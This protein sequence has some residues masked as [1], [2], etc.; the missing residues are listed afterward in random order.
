MVKRK[1]YTTSKASAEELDAFWRGDKDTYLRLYNQR[2]KA[3]SDALNNTVS[4]L[5]SKG[6]TITYNPR[7]NE[8]KEVVITAKGPSI[9]EKAWDNTSTD[10]KIDA[11]VTTASFIPGLDTAADIA[12]SANQFRQ[13]NWGWGLLGLGATFVPGLSMPYI[14]KGWDLYRKSKVAKAI[15]SDIS[16][17]IWEYNKHPHRLSPDIAEIPIQKGYMYHANSR[18]NGGVVRNGYVVNRNYPAGSTTIIDDKYASVR[19]NTTP[20]SD[21]IWWDL[22]NHNRGEEVLVTKEGGMRLTDPN[23]GAIPGHGNYKDS[24]RTTYRPNISEV[25]RFKY[26]PIGD[27]YTAYSPYRKITTNKMTLDELFTP[28]KQKI[29]DNLTSSITLRPGFVQDFKDVQTLKTFASKYGYTLPTGIERY[30]GEM[31]DKQYQKLLKKHNTFGRGVTADNIQ[32]AEKF[33]TTA[34][35]G[36]LGS[37]AFMPSGKTGIYTQNAM[38]PFGNFQG[39]VQRKLDFSGPRKTWIQKNDLPYLTSQQASEKLDKLKQNWFAQN[40]NNSSTDEMWSFLKQNHPELFNSS[41]QI[42]SPNTPVGQPKFGSTVIHGGNPGEKVLEAR[43]ILQMYKPDGK[44]STRGFSRKGYKNGGSL[45]KGLISVG[46]MAAKTIQKVNKKLKLRQYRFTKD[47]NAKFKTFAE[48]MYPIYDEVL[49]ELQLPKTQINNLIL[50]DAYESSYGLNPRGSQG[51]NLGGI[52]H[53]GDKIA[54]N[55]KKSLYKDGNYYID[56][57]NLYDYAK[58]KV[59]ILN[60][61]YD[62]I[63]AKDTNDFVDRL[64]GNNSGKYSYSVNKDGYHKNL[65]NMVSM[66]KALQEYLIENDNIYGKNKS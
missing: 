35:E 49:S 56:F 31:L 60:D 41:G 59:K 46:L 30:S 25:V 14:R 6:T 24:Y 38:A 33:L 48:I 61:R 40:I 43:N 55:Y 57:D 23:S 21:R 3:E 45:T 47:D 7:N 42:Y 2:K 62:A 44:T 20:E 9:V 17:K 5:E 34:H 1:I 39:I 63:N 51:Y 4:N 52:K 53:P 36:T 65:S 28:D 12:D 22:K 19:G 37:L 58:Y 8:L 64:H 66:S 13:G 18:P 32:E 27:T 50:Q 16:R 11:A 15:D 54:P 10:D 29:K 26:D